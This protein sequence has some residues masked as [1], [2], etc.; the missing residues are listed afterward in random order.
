V[1]KREPARDRS[2]DHED[3][4][5]NDEEPATA[6]IMAALQLT[7][8]WLGSVGHKEIGLLAVG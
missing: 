6:T 4:P 2:L 3:Y 5:S 1:P 8:R 7:K